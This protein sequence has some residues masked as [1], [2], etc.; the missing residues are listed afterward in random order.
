MT[1]GKIRRVPNQPSTPKHS[2]RIPDEIWD[3]AVEL[4]HEDGEVW[5][6]EVRKMIEGWIRRKLRQRK[7]RGSQ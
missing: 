6:E 3:L 7:L 5:S 2:I 1:S 4:A